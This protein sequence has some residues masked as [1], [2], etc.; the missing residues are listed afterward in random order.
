MSPEKE[1]CPLVFS[2]LLANRDKTVMALFF[3]LLNWLA[4]GSGDFSSL[5]QTI[6]M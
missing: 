6:Q 5:V 2:E 1:A 4:C 3:Y